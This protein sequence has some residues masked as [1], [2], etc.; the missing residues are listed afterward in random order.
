MKPL[1]LYELSAAELIVTDENMDYAF[2]S[3]YDSFN[4][5]FLSKQGN[6]KEIVQKM[7]WEAII[8]DQQT[9]I[10]WFLPNKY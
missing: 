10:D 1:D 8:C 5:L 7:N 4:T 3:I 2:M 6:S 9:Y